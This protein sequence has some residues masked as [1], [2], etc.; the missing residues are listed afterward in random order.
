[1]EIALTPTKFKK[2]QSYISK[3]SFF[4]TTIIMSSEIYNYQRSQHNAI[5]EKING[6]PQAH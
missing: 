3:D 4:T 2:M 1:L 5:G 6:V